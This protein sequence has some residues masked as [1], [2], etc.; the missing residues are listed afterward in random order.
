MQVINIP[1]INIPIITSA[2]Q[3]TSIINYHYQLSIINYH[4]RG[5]RLSEGVSKFSAL[6][7]NTT[8]VSHTDTP[9]H[10]HQHT[11]MP[12]YVC[13]LGYFP[14]PK[15]GYTLHN[16]NNMNTR[17]LDEMKTFIKECIAKF[18][19][20]HEV[21]VLSGLNRGFDI[22]AIHVVN[23]MNIPFVAVLPAITDLTNVANEEKDQDT[24]LVELLGA[25]K[26]TIIV[27]ARGELK[28]ETLFERDELMIKKADVVFAIYNFDQ[29]TEIGRAVSYCNQFRKPMVIVNPNDL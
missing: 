17:L 19:D 15:V 1:I 10:T 14:K 3:Y 28:K 9:N 13:V 16:D 29:N 22:D 26:D 2:H 12:Y 6:S 8:V 18:Q 11:K 23:E 4:Y 20:T 27:S 7:S 5:N 24:K 21:I 25:A